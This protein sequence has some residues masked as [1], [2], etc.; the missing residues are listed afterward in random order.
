MGCRPQLQASGIAVFRSE[1]PETYRPQ[2]RALGMDQPGVAGAGAGV[3]GAGAVAGVGIGVAGA[4]APAETAHMAEIQIP[5]HGLE[6]GQLSAPDAW[7]RV[8]A[9]VCS[10][11]W[12]WPFFWGGPKMVG[13]P[14]AHPKGLKQGTPMCVSPASGFWSKAIQR[15]FVCFFLSGF[16]TVPQTGH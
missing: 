10:T 13:F 5:L 8:G 16:E 12:A 14:V 2:K 3:A 1:Q 9:P 4:H 6:V 11:I 7:R 15:L